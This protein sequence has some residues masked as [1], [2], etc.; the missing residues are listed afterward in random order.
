[1]RLVRRLA[2]TLALS[3]VGGSALASGVA[4]TI[5]Q[6]PTISKAKLLKLGRIDAP[7][8]GRGVIVH[9]DFPA[10]H[11]YRTLA[12]RVTALTGEVTPQGTAHVLNTVFVRGKKGPDPEAECADHAF[13][14][15]GKLWLEQDIPVE[16]AINLRTVPKYMSPWLT[17]RS[18]RE[19]HHS[20]TG[21]NSK[22]E[23][24]DRIDFRFLYTGDTRKR[25]GYDGVNTLDFGRLGHAVGASYVWYS[26][27]RIYEA[28]LRLNKRYLWSNRPGIKRRYNVKNVAVHEIGHHLGLDDLGRGH[29]RL[30]MFGIVG[31]GEMR[32]ITL[33][34]GDVRGAEVVSP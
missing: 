11:P 6:A 25:V 28:D 14:P 29:A 1:M 12:G 21:T 26:G 13:V 16:F 18:L 30:T 15:V 22:C 33:G 32:K 17:T 31:K 3:L 23:E 8:R 10:G 34:R 19:A 24:E 9:L 7:P 2:L 20:W 5:A 4:D 27:A